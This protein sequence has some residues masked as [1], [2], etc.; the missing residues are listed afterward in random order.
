MFVTTKGYIGLARAGF[1]ISDLICVFHGGEVPFLLR[2]IDSLQEMFRF[3]GE[4]YVHGIMD[5]EAMPDL[6]RAGRE[7]FRLIWTAIIECR[8]KIIRDV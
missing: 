2:Q 5:G 3:V 7:S 4:C 6:D 8:Q 1:G